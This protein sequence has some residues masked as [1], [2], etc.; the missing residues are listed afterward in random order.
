VRP[1][2]SDDICWELGARKV[3]PLPTFPTVPP[4]MIYSGVIAIVFFWA[5]SLPLAS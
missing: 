4:E 5:F 2:T 1:R 3:T